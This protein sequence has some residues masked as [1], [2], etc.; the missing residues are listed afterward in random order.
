MPNKL[1]VIKVVGVS[2]SGKST[3]VKG[4]R[5]AGYDARPVSQEHSNVHDLW[6]QFDFPKVLIYLDVTLAM[7]EKRR[8]DVEWSEAARSI[9]IERLSHALEHA[10]LRIDTSELTP[11][12]ITQLALAFLVNQK[13]RHADQPLEA[14]P[15]TGSFSR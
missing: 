9:E 7:Q 10:D 4:L 6:K 5:A 2:A 14:V 15:A 3:L 11:Q 1:P 12:N 8:P 13:I